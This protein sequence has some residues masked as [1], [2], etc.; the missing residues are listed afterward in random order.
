MQK[1]KFVFDAPNTR[2]NVNLDMTLGSDRFTVKQNIDFQ[3]KDFAAKY[4]HPPLFYKR[5]LE[6]VIRLLRI[7]YPRGR[8]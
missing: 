4:L 7:P 1:R 2:N 3:L 8:P 5:L 6:N